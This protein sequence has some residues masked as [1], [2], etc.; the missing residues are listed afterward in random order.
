[1]IGRRMMMAGCLVMVRHSGKV[2][3]G[4]GSVV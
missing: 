1:M 4:T 2:G 3:G